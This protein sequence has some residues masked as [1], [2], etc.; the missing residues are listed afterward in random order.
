[1]DA[2]PWLDGSS[3]VSEELAEELLS[4]VLESFGL[5]NELQDFVQSYNEHVRVTCGVDDPTREEAYVAMRRVLDQYGRNDAFGEG[6]FWLVED[7][8][9]TEAPCIV[10]TR[11]TFRLPAI[12]LPELA[13]A[14]GLCSSFLVVHVNDAEGTILQSERVAQNGG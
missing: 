8:F 13:R 11:P 5:R 12:A 10:V 6:D 3:E 2:C 14:A 9:S 1:M 4:E 7:S